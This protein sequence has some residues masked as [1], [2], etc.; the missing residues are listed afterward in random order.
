VP[1]GPQG[2]WL[3][4]F[5]NPREI[6]RGGFGV[7]YVAEQTDLGRDVA[8]KILSGQ[9]DDLALA[10]FDRER[11]AMGALSA[12]PNIV[13]IFSSGLTDDGRPFIVM[14][15]LPGGAMAER[16]ERDGPLEWQET[17]DVGVKLS[18]AL[19]TAHRAG[20]L[21]RD[22][23]PENIFVSS[24]NAPK[25]G[26]FGIARVEGTPQTQSAVIT[27]SIAHAAPELIDGKP[28]SVQSDIYGLAST[29]VTLLT[30]A[31]P[32][33]RPTDESIV[34]VLSRITTE[35]L[36]DLRPLGVPAE[37]C[38]VVEQAMAKDPA[39]RFAS[40]EAFGRAIQSAQSRVSV[41]VTPLLIQGV[42]PTM[43]RGSGAPQAVI[44]PLDPSTAAAAGAGAAAA[45]VSP[46]TAPVVTPGASR[47]PP[48]TPPP[49]GPPG[50][51][52]PPPGVVTGQ[53]PGP[54]GS[55]APPPGVV[56]GQPP[57]P[58]GS[59]SPPPGVVTGQPT[60]PPIAGAPPPPGGV[61]GQPPGPPG[62]PAGTPPPPGVITGHAPG[63]PPS[64]S[65]KKAL[66]I[67][68]AALAA[69][70]L[71]LIVAFVVFAGGGDD[72]D[73]KADDSTTTTEEETTTTTEEET[74]TTAEGSLGTTDIPF[75]TGDDPA[76]DELAVD[77]S[78]GDMEAC[79]DL[80]V[81]SPVDTN[82]EDYGNSCGGRL[83]DGAAGSCEVELAEDGGG[84]PVE[85]TEIPFA[86]GDDPELDTLA[87]SCSEGDLA[88]CDSLF[89]ESPLDSNYEDYGNSC[90]GR[91]PD[92][93]GGTCESELG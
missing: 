47:F 39:M 35:P 84:D 42:D 4:G 28:P 68:L 34:P 54:P 21:H 10:R 36:P 19:E 61:A 7:V 20:V 1:D 8:V 29:L 55:G 76:L 51:G 70:L 74:T 72:G 3:P 75:A 49:T 26:D 12:H 32:F 92:G 45:S 65:S 53:P 37:L 62:S 48:S 33:T 41:E 30:G 60:G 24:L 31:P 18:S 59:S 69:V 86:L 23:K 40:V 22:M 5:E 14:E 9:L 71:L 88:A 11:R 89:V 64:P 27:A 17:A 56:T 78:E 38:E 77:C 46:P 25:I 43:Q 93:A 58:P 63:P 81:Q 57:G 79:D 52:A 85:A 66:W 80:Y 91:L 13:T 82:Y 67:G 16:V 87:T 73:E 83:P 2:D 90:G 6:G 15:Y 50:S 44:P